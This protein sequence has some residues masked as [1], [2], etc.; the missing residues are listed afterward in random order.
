M[1][2]KRSKNKIAIMVI[3]SVFMLIAIS[4]GVL[5][6]MI[7]NEWETLDGRYGDA[8]KLSANAGR[9]KDT[10]FIND[11]KIRITGMNRVQQHNLYVLAKVWGYVKYR[12][13][14]ITDGTL[15]WDAE[16]FRIMLVTLSFVDVDAGLWD[17]L[18]ST[19]WHE[20]GTKVD[21]TIK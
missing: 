10:E 19:Y 4:I 18:V 5:S 1:E 15:N 3:I 17:I 12:H 21:G 8:R 16:L 6:V 13:P 20:H 2:R 14:K 7:S 11:S 9:K